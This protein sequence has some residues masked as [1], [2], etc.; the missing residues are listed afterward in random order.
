VG[1][2]F[3]AEFSFEHDSWTM[4]VRKS[5]YNIT[6][7]EVEEKLNGHLIR[8][9]TSRKFKVSDIATFI[10]ERWLTVTLYG[11]TLDSAYL[12][13]D[14]KMGVVSKVVPFQFG[15]AAQVSF[16]L[17]QELDDPQVYTGDKEVLV[18]LR[19]K[20]GISPVSVSGSSAER[21]NWLIDR[22]ILDP[23][24]GGK[25]P[26]AVGPNGEKKKDL[27]LDIAKR[28]K[29]L[30][31]KQHH[32]DVL[33]TREDDRFLGLKDRT[34]FANS[35]DGKLFIS[36]HINSV[37]SKKERGFST[38]VLGRE[39]TEDALEIAQKENSVIE[40]EDPKEYADYQEATYILNAI[41]QNSYQKESLEMARMVNDALGK[42]T[43]LPQWRRGVY[44]AGFYVLV[45]ASMPCILVEAG[46]LSNTADR[47]YLKVR[48][49]KQ[50][51]A[52]ALCESIITFKKTYEKGIQ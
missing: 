12:A 42:R 7:I 47:N 28:L 33:M 15:E 50:K 4:G 22:I 23:G 40:F 3:P 5:R 10:K 8:F 35:H 2:V 25:H 38:W 36:I 30:L 6:G 20:R 16:L 27:T 49:N 31:E 14:R 41:A 37:R 43:T 13:S 52:E 17:D 34:Q 19:D 18:T 11:G 32:L 48:R 46:F 21:K 51:I 1:H 44:Q 39:K 29:N 9:N 26:G 45:G 24:H